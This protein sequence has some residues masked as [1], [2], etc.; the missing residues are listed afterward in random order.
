MAKT[1]MK[2]AKVP[3]LMLDAEG[4]TV[5]EITRGILAAQAVFD[6]AGVAAWDSAVGAHNCWAFDEFGDVGDGDLTPYDEK[7]AAIW[8]E[9]QS[10]AEAA[11]RADRQSKSVLS[12]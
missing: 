9:A 4:A 3:H 12:T 1:S 5:E 11:C 10:A 2:D 7:M 6:R 8:D